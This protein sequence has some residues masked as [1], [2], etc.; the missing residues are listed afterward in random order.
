MFPQVAVNCGHLKAGPGLKDCFQGGSLTQLL[1]GG[2]VSH[3]EG[4]SAGPLEC[5]HGPRGPGSKNRGRFCL[6][7]SDY[8]SQPPTARVS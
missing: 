7:S 1:A 6:C 4:L 5:P 8:G 3:D 2:L